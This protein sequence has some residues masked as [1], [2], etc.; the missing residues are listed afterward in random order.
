MSKMLGKRVFVTGANGLLG[1]AVLD[2]LLRQN[3]EVVALVR[4][5]EALVDHPRRVDLEIVV[6]DMTDVGGFQANLDGCDIVIHLAAFHREY[7]EGSGDVD[8]LERINVEGTMQLVKAAEK[9]GVD[10]FIFVSSAG[11]MRPTA[12]LLNEEAVL[13]LKS[14]NAYFFSK[15]R[16]EQRIDTYLSQGS[17]MDILIARPSML[18]GPQDHGPTVA[19]QFVRNFIEGK[20]AVVLPGYAVVLDARDAAKALVRMVDEGKSGERFILGGQRFSFLELNQRLERLS[21][22]PMPK[23]RPP[24]L[25]ACMLMGLRNLFGFEVPLRPSELR[26]MQHLRAPDSRKMEEMLGIQARPI[27]DTLSDTIAWF[28]ENPPR[29]QP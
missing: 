20:N 14:G 4:R 26:Y 21:G 28:R 13:D 17:R 8:P 23:R 25:V 12:R 10:R 7:R 27:D 6:G 19:G 16:A 29:A 3:D 22:V 9:A 15:V 11:V 5:P 18:L 24:Y 2:E 1:R